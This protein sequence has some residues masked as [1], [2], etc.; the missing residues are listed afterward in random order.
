M[1]ER[2]AV[3]GEGH[4]E[5]PAVLAAC[6]AAF[7]AV[8]ALDGCRSLCPPSA[9]TLLHNAQ[10]IEKQLRN[11]A[12]GRRSGLASAHALPHLAEALH[13]YSTVLPS[14]SISRCR[15]TTEAFACHF[16]AGASVLPSSL[17]AKGGANS[18]GQGPRRMG[19][20]EA[21]LATVNNDSLC[22]MT[23]RHRGAVHSWTSQ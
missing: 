19:V 9:W 7:V 17:H 23:S 20:C 15:R 2:F 10:A 22:R 13:M 16:C 8:P 1:K 21:L 6:A 5:L 12:Q 11:Q 14:Q 4:I 18:R 3:M